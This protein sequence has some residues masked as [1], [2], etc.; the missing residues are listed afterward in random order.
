MPI[1]SQTYCDPKSYAW[2]NEFVVFNKMAAE[3]QFG[4][5]VT[6]ATG[7]V[8]SRIIP[9]KIHELDISDTELI[10]NE[11]GCRLRSIDFLYSEAGVNRPL[12]P[13]DIPDRKLNRTTFR[14][15]INKV[16]NAIKDIIYSLYPD[17]KKRATKSYQTG[18]GFGYT[19][20]QSE[21]Y[22]EKPSK[23]LRFSRKT[24]LPGSIVILL[25]LAM[26]FFIP[27]MIRNQSK[28]VSIGKI[29]RKSIAVLPVSNLTGNTDLEYVGDGIQ[30]DITSR[31][32]AISISR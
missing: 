7:Y 11:L 16:A 18:T 14:D 31:F 10:E 1:I 32:G 13:A 26:I 12:K 21:P 27:K 23:G 2:Q 15:Q 20:G 24:I 5:D 30:D 22:S 4:R 17:P 9:I 19:N 25:I 29:V 6:V 8:C 28:E 3:D